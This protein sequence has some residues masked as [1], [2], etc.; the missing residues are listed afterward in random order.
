MTK[1]LSYLADR[2]L[3]ETVIWSVQR[4][5]ELSGTGDGRIWQAELAPP[6]WTADV[7]LSPMYSDDAE[8]AAALI[9]ALDGSREPFLLYNPVR[10]YPRKDVGGTA[11]SGAAVTIGSIAS[12]RRSLSLTNLPAG[13]VLSVGDKIQM[14]HG[15]GLNMF[16]EASADAVANSAGTTAQFSVFPRIKAGVV[17]GGTA[18]L[19][20]PACKMI[21]YPNSHNPGTAKAGITTGATFKAV[22]KR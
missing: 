15:D 14:P 7:T 12:D 11:I 17:A 13:Y 8:A 6:L 21:V 10:R 22:E 5:D 4:N 19:L 20:N 2:L 3:I 1:P 9:R 18:V 16:V